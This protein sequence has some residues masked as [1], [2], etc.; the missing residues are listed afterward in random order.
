M[1]KF[2][3]WILAV[4]LCLVI[5]SSGTVCGQAKS[6]SIKIGLITAFSGPQAEIGP[7][8]KG[9]VEMRLQ[10]SNFTVAGKKVELVVEDGAEDTSISLEKAK[11]LVEMDKVKIIIGGGNMNEDI[12]KYAGADAYGVDAMAAVTFAKKV[13]ASTR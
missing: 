10:E 1:K 4:A 5:L 2:R 9:A 11:K 7:L 3:A 6:D 12:R 13:V 8:I